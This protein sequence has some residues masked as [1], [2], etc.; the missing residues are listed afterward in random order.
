MIPVLGR[1]VE[2]GEQSF[3]VLGQTGDR[4]VVLRTIFL[5]ERV[6]RGVRSREGWRPIDLA[7]VCLHVD[8]DRKGDFVEHVGD[9]VNPTALMPGGGK[10]LLNRLPKAE[11]T[12][13]DR[14]VGR[15]LEPASLGVDEKLA[16]ALRALAHPGLEA[17]ELLF[18][19]GCGSDQHQH[20]FRALFHT[21]LQVDAVRHTYTYRRAERSRFCQAS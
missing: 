20:A 8:L 3:P 21:R 5:G 2:E 13:A 18:A 12:I 17:N 6:N 10:D 11:R 19:L 14:E 15:D 16:P 9:L 7:K 1:E 4:A